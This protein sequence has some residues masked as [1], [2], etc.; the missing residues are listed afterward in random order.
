MRFAVGCLSL[1]LAVLAG[2][3]SPPL[4]EAEYA[5]VAS[6]V[7]MAAHSEVASPATLPLESHLNGPHPVHLFV[8]VALERNPEIQAAQRRVAA[9][10]ETIPQVTALDDPM[11]QDTFYPIDDHALQTAAGRLPNTLSVS[12]KFPWLS[13][14]RVRGEIAEQETRIAL[15]ELATTRLKI[16]EE[17]H[18]AWYDI[19][20]HQRAI[21]ITQENRELLKQLV[22]SAAARYRAGGSQQDVFRAELELDKLREQLIVLRQKLRLA[23]SDLAA[24]LH[25][26][27]ELEPLA[28]GPLSPPS[29]PEAVEELY[30]LAVRCRPELQ[31]K[32]HAIVRDERRQKLARLQ[33]RPDF[34]VGM[35]W[36]AV[37]EDDALSRVANGH[38]NLN[39]TIGMSLPVW[40]DKLR[41]GVR[42]A[43][44][45]TVESA[46]RYDAT[47][48]ETFRRIRRLIAEADSGEQQIRLFRDSILP[49]S[50]QTF[51]VSLAEYRVGRVDFLQVVS[52]YSELLMFRIQLARLQARLGQTL[53]S[54]ERVVGCELAEFPLSDEVTS[55][56]DDPHGPTE[57]KLDEAAVS[58][59]PPTTVADTSARPETGTRSTTAGWETAIPSGDADAPET[60]K[61]SADDFVMP[62]RPAGAGASSMPRGRLNAT[63][64]IP[65]EDEPR[66]ESQP[67]LPEVPR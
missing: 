36:S 26:S 32:L 62:G 53:A 29:A 15:T 2:C 60:A 61:S 63:P 64:I 22:E 11:L 24:L 54:L 18:L 67:D 5:E 48:D 33:Y 42:E 14:L 1:P 52:N 50:E 16:V 30:D 37:T 9:Q 47:R 25:A 10:A 13:K 12:Q 45:R 38:D 23:Q 19:A 7:Q 39:V 49:R 6:R 35:G 43:E 17:V 51:R 55:P 27:P 20:Y 21:E 56:A 40:R 59:R 31:E 4:P 57:Q 8:Q 34:T 58:Q 28:A 65:P 66:S 3:A 41:A 44:H 46:R